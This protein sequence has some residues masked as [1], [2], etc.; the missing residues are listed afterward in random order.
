MNISNALKILGLISFLFSLPAVAQEPVAAKIEGHIFKPA[1]REATD[2]RVGK[3]KV[4]PGFKV[5]KFA[6]NLGKP[7]MI[8]VAENGDVYVTVREQDELVRLQDTD[9]DGKA[10]KRETVAELDQVHGISIHNGKMYL[11]TVKELYQAQFVPDGGISEPELIL[12]DLPD[13]GQHPNRTLAFG[14]DNKL[15]VSIGSTC[16]ACEETNKEHAT[17]LQMNANGKDRKVF[18]KGLRNTMGFAWHPQTFE[19]WGMDHGMDWLGDEEQKEE[20]NKLEEGA[21][22]GWPYIYGNGKLNPADQPDNIKIKKLAAKAKS[23]VLLYPEAHAAAL[24]MLFYTGNQ[25]PEL[26]RNNAFVAF[27]GSW[28]RK[29]PV[30]YKVGRLVFNEEGQPE[31][32]EDFMSGF[33]I[34]NNKAHF[35]RPVGLAIHTDGSLLVTDDSNG[36]VYRVYYQP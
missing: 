35:G 5:E 13:G 27:H 29:D 6:E 26:Y 36:V 22:Y 28:N 19:L 33:L 3:L 18:A 21:D 7:R 17:I 34:E 11:A 8:A 32:F 24:G 12:D 31:A 4:P 2:E 23:P 25:F 10:D 30:G 14:P 16:N 20:L 9:G 15:Y 1:K